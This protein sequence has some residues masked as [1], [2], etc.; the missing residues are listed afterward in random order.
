MA[1]T[2][3]QF[4]HEGRIIAEATMGGPPLE[5]HGVTLEDPIQGAV[6]YRVRTPEHYP[7]RP[8]VDYRLTTTGSR[9]AG[10]YLNPTVIVDLELLEN[11]KVTP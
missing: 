11:T 9:R 2:L 6:R 10:R 5:G 4:R 1:V 3:V 8:T 7:G